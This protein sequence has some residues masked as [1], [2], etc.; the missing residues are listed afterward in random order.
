M[1]AIDT[2]EAAAV[3]GGALNAYLSK[4]VGEKQGDLQGTCLQ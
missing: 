3:N 2:T 1:V 4:V